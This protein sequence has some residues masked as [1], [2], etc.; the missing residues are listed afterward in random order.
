MPSTFVGIDV[1]KR[2]FTAAIA[3][4]GTPPAQARRLPAKTFAN[5][6]DGIAAFVRWIEGNGG[7][8]AC[9]CAEST[10][11]YSLRLAADLRAR[12]PHLPALTIVNPSGIMGTAAS[13]GLRDKSDLLD[14]AVI[15][16]HAL[17][18]RP[19]PTES[20][21][22]RLDEL[23][24][25]F[26]LRDALV[27]DRTAHLNRLEQVRNRSVSRLLEDQIKALDKQIAK[28]DKAID[29]CIAADE[30]LR[31]DNELLQ[32]VRGI[33]RIL[34]IAILAEFGDLRRWKRGQ[35]ASY[36][37]V[38]PRTHESGTSVFRAPRMIKGGASRL[39]RVLYMAAVSF[40][41]SG[42]GAESHRRFQERGKTKM[43]SIGAQMRK[44]LLIA[45]A[46]VVSNT[47][48]DITKNGASTTH[49][50]P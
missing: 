1:S 27:R 7:T 15:A 26:A 34:A 33:G 23:N 9:L 3:A 37:G 47:P 46:V 11:V 2:E 12:A 45:R 41:R 38:Y 28:V 4:E 13:L 20:T 22:P 42:P 6:A 35:V 29:R 25:L 5:S 21:S 10:G 32:S 39:R 40:V 16:I 43:C 18:H 44:L 17:V 30:Q 36:A 24:E 31:R 50:S 49:Q 8:T 48:F 14:A 19:E